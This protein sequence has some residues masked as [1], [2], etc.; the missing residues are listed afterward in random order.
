MR[1]YGSLATA[2]VVDSKPKNV[3]GIVKLNVKFQEK[4]YIFSSSMR[5]NVK[6]RKLSVSWF[7][8][9]RLLKNVIRMILGPYQNSGKKLM[10]SFSLMLK[11]I[12]TF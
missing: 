9:N 11:L 4:V 3:I 12:A 7:Q 10:K 5:L 1:S 6:C 2:K 8:K